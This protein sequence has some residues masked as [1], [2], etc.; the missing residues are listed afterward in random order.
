MGTIG[1][2]YAQQ[3]KEAYE[4]FTP[5]TEDN[6]IKLS[7]FQGQM[8]PVFSIGKYKDL[9]VDF[10]VGIDRDYINWCLSDKATFCKTTK[11]YIKT[12]IASHVL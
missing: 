11:D 4:S 3:N 1:I 2:F 5:L 9:P 6:F 10:V 8:K 12:F 7:D